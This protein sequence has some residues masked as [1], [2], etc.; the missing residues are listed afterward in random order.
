[1]KSLLPPAAAGIKTLAMIDTGQLP[2]HAA[3]ATRIGRFRIPPAA[4]LSAQKASS[5]PA[6]WGYQR[7]TCVKWCR[8]LSSRYRPDC[9]KFGGLQLWVPTPHLL[10][11]QAAAPDFLAARAWPAPEDDLHH[12]RLACLQSM[13]PGAFPPP[14]VELKES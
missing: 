11:P 8:K 12:P 5:W 7:G 13:A 2:A 1:M 4:R 6:R 14:V 3:E 10:L 9:M